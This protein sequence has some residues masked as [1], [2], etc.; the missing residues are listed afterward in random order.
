MY[1][2]ISVGCRRKPITFCNSGED[3]VAVVLIVIKLWY[4]KYAKNRLFFVLTWSIFAGPVTYLTR[5]T[6]QQST[7]EDTIARHN[8]IIGYNSQK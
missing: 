1:Y 4:S 6:T 2:P 3:F 7:A 8:M 5:E